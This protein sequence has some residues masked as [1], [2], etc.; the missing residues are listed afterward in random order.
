MKPQRL[1]SQPS[2][3]KTVSV[4]KVTLVALATPVSHLRG[5]L[6]DVATGAPISE[7]HLQLT[8][9]TGKTY[10]ALTTANGGFHL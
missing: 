6:T 9:K 5:I 7:V 8:D 4:D 10:E 3:D 1:M 2:L